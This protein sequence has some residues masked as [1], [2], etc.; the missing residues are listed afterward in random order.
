MHSAS[1]NGRVEDQLRAA[2][3]GYKTRL[4]LFLPLL[5]DLVKLLLP[6]N[7]AHDLWLRYAPAKGVVKAEARAGR[8]CIAVEAASA[9]EGWMGERSR[10]GDRSEEPAVQQLGSDPSPP[11]KSEMLAS[12]LCPRVP[13]VFSVLCRVLCVKWRG[14]VIECVSHRNCRVRIRVRVRVRAGAR[15]RARAGA[16]SASSR[17]PVPTW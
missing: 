11:F 17:T 5:A 16:G 10:G 14:V 15:A 6:P 8:W 3:S 2:L 12:V 4:Y 9:P 1:S 13:H 7:H